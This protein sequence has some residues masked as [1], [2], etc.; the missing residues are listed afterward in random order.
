[1]QFPRVQRNSSARPGDFELLVLLVL[2]QFPLSISPS[3]FQTGETRL[4]SSH[5]G[6][7]SWNLGNGEREKQEHEG[8]SGSKRKEKRKRQVLGFLGM[9]RVGLA[10]R[11]RGKRGTNEHFRVSHDLSP[12]HFLKNSLC[13]V[14]R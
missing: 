7:C 6:N 4:R 8:G 14:A 13:S 5:V 10:L 9:R 1:M 2:S 3:Q 12:Y 11:R